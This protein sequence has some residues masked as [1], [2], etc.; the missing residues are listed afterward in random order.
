MF[1]HYPPFIYKEDE[2]GNYDNVDE[3]ARSWLVAQMKKPH[4]EGVFAGMRTIPGQ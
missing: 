1:M 2:R 4:V 3:P